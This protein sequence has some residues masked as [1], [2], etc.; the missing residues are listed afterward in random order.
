MFRHNARHRK[1]CRIFF[2]PRFFSLHFLLAAFS[3]H[4][5]SLARLFIRL[6]TIFVCFARF[7]FSQNGAVVFLRASSPQK[8]I[9]RRT[10]LRKAKP[11][12]KCPLAYAFGGAA[13]EGICKGRGRFYIPAP[14][15]R[16][17]IDRPVRRQT[18]FRGAR[19]PRNFARPAKDLHNPLINFANIGTRRRSFLQSTKDLHMHLLFGVT[20]CTFCTPINFYAIYRQA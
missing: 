12:S 11:S 15:R 4:S 8:N 1:F 9:Y 18:K 6:F 3:S 10:I 19:R 16:G 14:R 5:A 20:L 17:N 2:S 7:M 13:A